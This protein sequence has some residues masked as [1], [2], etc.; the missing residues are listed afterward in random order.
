MSGGF[1]FNVLDKIDIMTSSSFYLAS[2]PVSSSSSSSGEGNK[3]R[4]PN[5]ELLPVEIVFLLIPISIKLLFD[6]TSGIL[7]ST[8]LINQLIWHVGNIIPLYVTYT[9]THPRPTP[10]RAYWFSNYYG[11]SQ[12][13]TVV[14]GHQQS[15][16]RLFNP[17]I[18]YRSVRL[19]IS[20]GMP[21]VG[22]WRI[23]G[24][25]WVLPL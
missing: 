20:R 7:Y 25:E 4:E 2:Q 13:N 3:G 6:L 5:R 19:S 16:S 1:R 21:E 11:R 18:S 17:T 8:E 24:Y 10:A 23:P 14:V 22:K 12:E 15:S 9:P